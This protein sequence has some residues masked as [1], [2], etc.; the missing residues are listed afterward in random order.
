MHVVC[1]RHTA[2]T[3]KDKD[4]DME[5]GEQVEIVPLPAIEP[6]KGGERRRSTRPVLFEQAA[7]GWWNPRYSSM[8]LEN[9]YQK[10]SFPQT[11]RR[12]R[13]ALIYVMLAC[14]SWC[15][16]FA[17]MRRAHWGTYLVA[18]LV[19]LIA[20]GIIMALT[21]WSDMYGQRRCMLATSVVHTL[22]LFVFALLPFMYIVDFPDMSIVGMFTTAVEILLLIYTVIP[23]PFY[24]SISFGMIFSVVFE[25]LNAFTSDMKTPE[26][27]VG[28]ALLHVCIHLIGIHVSIMTQVRRRSTFLKV[29]QSVMIR[30]DLAKEKNLKERMIESLMPPA[31][32]EKARREMEGLPEDDGRGEGRPQIFRALHVSDMPNV[33]IL[34][35]DIVGFTHM[36]SNKTAPHLVSLLNDLFGRFDVLCKKNNCEKI[37]TLGDCYYCVAGCPL[38]RT[39]HAKCCVDM[40]LAMCVAIQEFDRDH[41][42]EVNMRVGVHTGTV[43]CGLVGVR[44]FKFDVWSHDVT[45]ANLMESS[46]KA[47]RV[48]ISHDTYQF[49]KDIYEMESGEPVEGTYCWVGVSVGVKVRGSYD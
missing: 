41:N 31:V 6:L 29:G 38:P 11:R 36:S 4:K 18:G 35:A 42:E 30:H 47:G 39:D 32:A 19:L 15:I 13:Y 34:F 48:H 37:S 45:L 20:T 43:L 22:L 16:F 40:G 25:L 23:L 9:E 1:C 49:V 12:F 21:F 27:I 17:V 3:G 2:M 33:S 5:N 44:R 24:A 7:R 8:S 46:G 26:V 10:L 14:V 28:R